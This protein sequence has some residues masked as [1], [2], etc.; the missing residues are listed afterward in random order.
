MAGD[1]VAADQLDPRLAE[2]P[3]DPRDYLGPEERKDLEEA[4]GSISR[5]RREAEATSGDLRMH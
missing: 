2:L 3:L 4:L 1:S 5:T